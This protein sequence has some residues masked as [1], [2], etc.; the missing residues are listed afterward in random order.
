MPDAAVL[1]ISDT[2]SSGD[3]ADTSGP[4]AEELLLEIGLA[5]TQ[6]RVVPDDIATIQKAVRD[7]VGQVAVIVTT[8]GTGIAPRDVTPEALTPLFDR[9]LPGFGEIMRT[10]TF[11][12]T[13]LSIISRGGG[14]LIGTTLVVM[15]PGSPKGVRECLTLVGPA[16]KHLIKICSGKPTDCQQE[17]GHA[18]P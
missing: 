5:V 2:R 8:G 1:T 12:R 14:G 17:L 18:G 7:L 16:I 11:S 3:R 9:P 15:L 6:R 10:G 4:T 13:P